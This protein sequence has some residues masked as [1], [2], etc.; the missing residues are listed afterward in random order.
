L[1]PAD[2]TP[3]ILD[4]GSAKV[5]AAFM[6]DKLT[7]SAQ[8]V[9]ISQDGF[10]FEIPDTYLFERGTAQPNRKFIEV[11]DRLTT[12]TS[13]LQDSEIKLTSMIF[14]QTVSDGTP[15]TA[16]KVAHDR[17]E[18]ITNKIRGS[19][20]HST[21]NVYGATVIKEKKGEIDQEKVIGYI[22]F[23]IHQKPESKSKK[24]QRKIESLFNNDAV[25][26]KGF[27]NMRDEIAKKSRNARGVS[28]PSLRFQNPADEEIQRLKASG[29]PES[30]EE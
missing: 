23:S 13:G 21:N 7:D 30:E 24:P 15:A 22:H 1:E 17:L 2:K 14:S 3:N 4:M 28:D 20:E 27:E 18:L 12:I 9:S 16:K 5:V 11:M 10:E 29:L 26:T 19:F 8:N 6:A 25:E